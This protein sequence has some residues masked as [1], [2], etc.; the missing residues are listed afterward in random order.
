[1]LHVP[2]LHLKCHIHINLHR[3][4]FR[5]GLNDQSLRGIDMMPVSIH[6]CYFNCVCK[7]N[8]S[9]WRVEWVKQAWMVWSRRCFIYHDQQLYLQCNFPIPK[10][11]NNIIRIS[12][13]NTRR[14][15]LME[16]SPPFSSNL[17]I[18]QCYTRS[19][20]TAHRSAYSHRVLPIDLKPKLWLCH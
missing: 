1:M 5:P 10:K 3:V 6:F 2:L 4:C 7:R 8:R 9:W 16:W 15:K 18:A 19:R 20:Q 17:G 12:E 14:E 11:M 13:P